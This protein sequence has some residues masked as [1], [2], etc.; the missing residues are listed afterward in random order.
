MNA[1]G[2]LIGL[3]CFAGILAYWYFIPYQVFLGINN[4]GNLWGPIIANTFVFIISLIAG[5][6]LTALLVFVGVVAL[7][8]AADD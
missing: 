1:R 8:A 6:I 7:V 2:V 5:I 4:A 3:L